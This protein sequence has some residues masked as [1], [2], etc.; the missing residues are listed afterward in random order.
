MTAPKSIRDFEALIA[1]CANAQCT[2]RRPQRDDEPRD[3][4]ASPSLQD[5]DYGS[6]GGGQANGS[7]VLSRRGCT[8]RVCGVLGCR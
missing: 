8:S 3:A 1:G 6:R 4:Q 2:G 7:R 5:F